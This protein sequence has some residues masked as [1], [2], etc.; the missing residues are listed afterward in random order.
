MTSLQ[1]PNKCITRP[2]GDVK[3]QGTF[4]EM[5]NTPLCD[6]VVM[7]LPQRVIKCIET[8]TTIAY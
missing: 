5:F 4:V 8:K 1:S 3:K 2:Q 7:Y 6:K